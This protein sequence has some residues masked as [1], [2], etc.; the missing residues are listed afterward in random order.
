MTSTSYT[1]RL[2]KM[3]K[4][5]QAGFRKSKSLCK[6]ILTW[7]IQIKSNKHGH[8]NSCLNSHLP[9]YCFRSLN[10]AIFPVITCYDDSMHFLRCVY[11]LGIQSELFYHR[12]RSRSHPLVIKSIRLKFEL[13]WE[14]N[15]KSH[16]YTYT[17]HK[18]NLQ[19]G[20][21]VDNISRLFFL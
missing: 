11:R 19:H 21:F 13:E 14:P 18:T 2:I 5:K 9:V 10:C 16:V 15:L 17:L 8:I 1:P 4:N 20:W 12:V 6:E 3:T 7:P